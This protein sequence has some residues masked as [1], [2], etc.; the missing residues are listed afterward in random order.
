MKSAK[1]INMDGSGRNKVA[2]AFL[3]RGIALPKAVD[4]AAPRASAPPP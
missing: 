3:Q 4:Q 1:T 2:A